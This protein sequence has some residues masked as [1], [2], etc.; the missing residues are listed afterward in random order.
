MVSKQNK[1]FGLSAWLRR[2]VYTIRS[3][4]QRVA[5]HILNLLYTHIDI[6][7]CVIHFYLSFFA[8]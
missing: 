2:G 5:A 4:L 7:G 1:D 8:G 6:Q 3:G